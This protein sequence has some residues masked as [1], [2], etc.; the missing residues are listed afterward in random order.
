TAP[1]SNNVTFTATSTTNSSVQDTVSTTA[2]V[3]VVAQVLLDPDRNGTVTSPGTIQ[4]THTL[5]NNS[6]AP[7]TCSI[8]GNGGSFGWTYQ[9]ST[10]G[11]TWSNNL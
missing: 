1:G 4:Y 5:L 7:A 10:D 9:Y 8:S 6:N 3:N 2:T 11:T